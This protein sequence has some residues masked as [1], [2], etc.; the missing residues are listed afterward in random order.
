MTQ[1]LLTMA[2]GVQEFSYDISFSF[3]EGIGIVRIYRWEEGIL[4]RIGIAIG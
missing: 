4:E 2:E 3:S 1:E